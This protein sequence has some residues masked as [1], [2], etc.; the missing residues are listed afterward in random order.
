MNE[1]SKKKTFILICDN[2]GKRIPKFKIGINSYVEV[3][4]PF[5]N[6]IFYVKTDGTGRK[7]Q[8]QIKP[9]DEDKKIEANIIN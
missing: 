5:C 7:I 4:C 3:E 6:N 9:L 8:C 1:K 2:C